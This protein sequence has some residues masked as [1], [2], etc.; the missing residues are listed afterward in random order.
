[1]SELGYEVILAGKSHVGPDAV[2][3]WDAEMPTIE[4]DSGPR[5]YL[6]LEQ[7]KNYFINGKKPFCMFITSEYPH[8]P[9]YNE[10][11]LDE[12]DYVTYPALAYNK[13]DSARINRV[14]SGKRYAGYYRN[15]EEDQKQLSYILDMVDKYLSQNT[16]FMY[17][18][19]H[20]ITGK[21]TVYDR[22]LHTPFVA[23]WPEVIKPGSKSDVMINYVDVLPTLIDVI[24]GN[25][26]DD[27]DGRS[28]ADVF[29]G[30]ENE[31]HQYVYGVSTNQNIRHASV[32]PSRSIRSK[33]FKYII[34]FNSEEVVHNNLTDNEIINAF[35]KRG[36][37]KFE[38]VP[39]EELF[40]IATDPFETENIAS[41][42]DFEKT[43]TKLRE[44]LFDWM[45][46]Q[47]DFLYEEGNMPLLK[48][49]LHPLDKQSEWNNI[50]D[51][52]ENTLKEDY[53][54][55]THY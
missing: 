35:I 17:S 51:D 7:I 38:N 50:P 33:D 27:I 55:D 45:K 20:G 19:D 31:I 13:R 49:T 12:E 54:Y 46:Q 47:G 23:R 48:P 21:F 39:Y 32:F 6:P 10:P 9:Y 18:A 24:G 41:N 52:L 29:V 34:N 44:A 40:Y 36:A 53:Y 3:N 1:L 5:K 15:I 26:P 4:S 8:G 28:F 43:K 25:V 2:F 22:G 37:E 14:N 42:P 11:P 16:L 30:N